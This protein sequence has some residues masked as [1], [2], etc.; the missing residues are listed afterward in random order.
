[1]SASANPVI[2][3]RVIRRGMSPIFDGRH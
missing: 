2:A 3:S 1:M